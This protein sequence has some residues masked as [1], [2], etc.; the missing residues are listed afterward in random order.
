MRG[1]TGAVPIAST[2]ARVVEDWCIPAS[3]SP[4]PNHATNLACVRAH[5]LL[6]DAPRVKEG[7]ITRRATE[8]QFP[9]L[10]STKFKGAFERSPWRMREA[11]EYRNV[12]GRLPNHMEEWEEWEALK[13]EKEN[14]IN[15]KEGAGT[16]KELASK[17]NSVLGAAFIQ[18]TGKGKR[19][20]KRK[21]ISIVEPVL[22]PGAAVPRR[23]ASLTSHL[24]STK[25]TVKSS[26][27]PRRS[28]GSSGQPFMDI[29]IISPA[30]RLTSTPSHKR[31]VA[32]LQP[33]ASV[34]PKKS[35]NDIDLDGAKSPFESAEKWAPGEVPPRRSL[36]MDEVVL[37]EV[38]HSQVRRLV[39]KE[40]YLRI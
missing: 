1:T 30:R 19:R 2:S 39:L 35:M 16:V 10:V 40:S 4:S 12:R 29:E 31:P 6:V 37:F 13:R 20:E 11:E 21:S 25:P 38:G 7:R 32:P 23:S 8:K 27:K 5:V 22:V 18:D 34:S 3:R 36:G 33:K 26:V 15:G 9:A 28:Q 14:R 24:A 17:E